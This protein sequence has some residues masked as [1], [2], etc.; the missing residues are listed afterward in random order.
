MKKL[1]FVS[2]T[3][4]ALFFTGCAVTPFQALIYTQN[5]SPTADLEVESLSSVSPSKKGEATCTNIL[6]IVA[7]GD[8]SVKEAMKNGGITKVHHVDYSN[9]NIL[10]IINKGTFIVWGE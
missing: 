5:T 7:T 4:S 9:T 8:C 3:S 6:G 10:G 2:L 1:L